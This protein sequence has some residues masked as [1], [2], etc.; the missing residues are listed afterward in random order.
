M[1]ST[2]S[3]MA[4]LELH[5]ELDMARNRAETGALTLGAGRF[6]VDVVEVGALFPSE[7]G[8]TRMR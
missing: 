8:W 7:R 6:G 2:D 5:A 1:G 4:T 3:Q